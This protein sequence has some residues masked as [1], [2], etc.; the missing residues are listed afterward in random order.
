[1]M[2][3]FI[4]LKFNLMHHSSFIITFLIFTCPVVRFT[5]D[6]LVGKNTTALKPGEPHQKRGTNSFLPPHKDAGKA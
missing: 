2:D 3:A 1:M 6:K 5:S 4:R